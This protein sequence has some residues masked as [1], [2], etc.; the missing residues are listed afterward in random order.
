[1]GYLQGSVAAAVVAHSTT[2][3]MVIPQPQTV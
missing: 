1:L 2:P 3:V